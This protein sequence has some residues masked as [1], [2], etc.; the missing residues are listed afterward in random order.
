MKRGPFWRL[1]LFHSLVVLLLELLRLLVEGVKDVVHVFEGRDGMI[2]HIGGLLVLEYNQ[3][4]AALVE[5][6]LDFLVEDHLTEF[7]EDAIY[8]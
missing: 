7:H 8:W 4:I 3:T 2:K 6:S 1:K 5:C